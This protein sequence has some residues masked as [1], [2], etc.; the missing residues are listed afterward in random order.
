MAGVCE[1]RARDNR[2]YIMGSSATN[3]YSFYV[4]QSAYDEPVKEHLIVGP[5]G[6]S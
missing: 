6:D 3:G 1:P 4:M 2:V 5:T